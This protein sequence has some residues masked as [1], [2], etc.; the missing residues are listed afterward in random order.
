[1]ERIRSTF[2]RTRRE[3]RVALMPY[4]PVGYPDLETTLALAPALAAAG[5][6][7]FELGVPYSDPQA[8]GAT[9]Q[10]ATHRALENGVTPRRCLEVAA[11]V[12]RSVD[13]PLLLMSYYNPVLRFGNVA[14]CQ[15]AAAAGV[16]GLIVPDLPPEEAGELRE[17]ARAAGLDLIFLV[18]PTST[19]ERLRIVAEAASGFIYCVSLAGVTGARAQL[20]AGLADYLAR[21]RRFTDLPLAVGFGISRPEH[22]REVG[23]H[24]D[25]AIVASALVDRLDRLAPDERVAGAAAYLRELAVAGGAR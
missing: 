8:D 15:A 22:V 10:R 12:R 17:A 7:L 11:E 19:D 20:S 23:Q 13:V 4:L 16:D 5:A 24:A 3:R 18:A 25:G 9:L 14:F 2:E 6:D 1:M 21:V